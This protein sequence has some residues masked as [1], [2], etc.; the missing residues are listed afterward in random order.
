MARLRHV[1]EALVELPGIEP[2]QKRRS[3]AAVR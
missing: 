3:R 2:L 1:S